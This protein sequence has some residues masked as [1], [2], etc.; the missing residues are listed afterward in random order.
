MFPCRHW[1]E[2]LTFD[3]SSVVGAPWRCGV[4]T[5]L[6][7]TAGIWLGRQ[8]GRELACQNGAFPDCIIVVLDAIFQQSVYVNILGD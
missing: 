8:L 2:S 7:G 6:G 4:M 5:T 3:V 1:S